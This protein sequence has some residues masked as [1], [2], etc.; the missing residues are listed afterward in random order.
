MSK[1]IEAHQRLLKSAQVLKAF[2]EA[3]LNVSLELLTEEPQPS[4]ENDVPFHEDVHAYGLWGLRPS[5]SLADGDRAQVYEMCEAVL[6]GFESMHRQREELET[7]QN[8]LERAMEGEIPSNVIAFQRRPPTR[9]S[10]PVGFASKTYNLRLDCLI[11]SPSLVEVH[12]MATELHSSSS[13]SIFMNYWELAAP[14]RASLSYLLSLGAITLFIPKLTDVPTFEQEI[15]RHLVMQNT[16]ERPLL[17]VGTD[18]PYAEILGFENVD[19]ELLSLLMRAYI[20]LSKPFSEYKEQG[21]IHYFLD[22]L[23]SRPT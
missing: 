10:R 11:E 12:K 19:S 13:R 17:M 8:H 3:K 1:W 23:S 7:L 9:F 2:Y 22:S 6:C 16:L 18:V 4:L 5:K 20:K 21:L 14:R 15:L